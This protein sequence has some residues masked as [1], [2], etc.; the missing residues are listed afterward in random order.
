MKETLMKRGLFTSLFLLAMVVSVAAFAMD[1]STA[2]RTGVVGEKLDGYVGVVKAENGVA[3]LAADI[4]ARR[5]AE[6]ER[7]SKQNGQPVSVVAKLA[8][9]QVIGG[10]PG[11][12]LY[13]GAD[14]SWKTK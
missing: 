5:K 3:E 2:R 12:S 14:G 4:N 9:E 13:Q 6:Y 1:L 8:A 7:I 10:L 11:G